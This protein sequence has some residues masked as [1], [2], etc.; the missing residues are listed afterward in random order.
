MSPREAGP[1]RSV[2]DASRAD[3]VD[4]GSQ[5]MCGRT[6][7]NLE[8][9]PKN[10]GRCGTTCVVPNATASC[11]AGG[12]GIAACD[13]GFFDAD[14]DPE[15]GC[16]VENACVPGEACTTSCN[17]TGSVTCNGADAVCTAPAETCN[18]IDDDCN[19]SCDEGG[20]AGC[21]VG[22]HRGV[23]NGHV[24]TTDLSLASRSP[25]RLEVENFFYLYGAGVPDTRPL[26]RCRKG[27]GRFFL[28][29]DTACEGAGSQQEQLG[30]IGTAAGCGSVPLYRA[31]SGSAG[32]HFYTTSLGE[33]DNAVANLGYV[34]EGIP[35]YVWR[36][37]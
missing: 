28:T 12:C 26:F 35:G 15:T 9:D 31:Y 21:R 10:C 5:T 14:G 17:S 13:L 11:N 32:N 2:P 4:C 33:R 24:F 16:E 27:D 22:I 37:P 3:A 30:F 23:G 29:T 6:C 19:G 18:A 7:A 20:I 25:F 36:A 34:A 8:T 1:D